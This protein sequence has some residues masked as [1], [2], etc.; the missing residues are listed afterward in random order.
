[1]NYQPTVGHDENEGRMSNPY[2]TT[3][4]SE[5]KGGRTRIVIILAVVVVALLIGG[6]FYLSA[7][8]EAPAPV[9][10]GSQA[11]DITVMKPGR[12]AIE[13]TITATGTIAARRS[14]PVGVVG[15]GGRVVSVNVEQGQW[16]NAGQV[17]ASIDRS[18]QNQQARAHDFTFLCDGNQVRTFANSGLLVRL[19]GDDNYQ[20]DGSTA[21]RLDG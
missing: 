17:L 9:D 7:T 10:A 3:P 16:V 19:P 5:S 15:E 1:M 8:N 18:V 21:R 12:G 6:W 20:L 11:A 2:T 14:L 4:D 13:G